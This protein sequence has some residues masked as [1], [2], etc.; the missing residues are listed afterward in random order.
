MLMLLCLFAGSHDRS[1]HSVFLFQS[2]LLF[3]I[4]ACTCL[5]NPVGKISRSLLFAAIWAP[6]VL[7]SLFYGMRFMANALHCVMYCGS[8]YL[9]MSVLCSFIKQRIAERISVVVPFV[10]ILF[11]VLLPITGNYILTIPDDFLTRARTAELLVWANPF[12]VVS[13]IWDVDL[14]RWG[15][16]YEQSVIGSSY[17]YRIPDFLA[18]SAAMLAASVLIRFVD[19]LIALFD[20]PAKAQNDSS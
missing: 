12:A 1:A 19:Y 13:G 7:I 17:P 11:V 15:W 9:L 16:V 14:M 2:I 3:F 4:T 10:V 20:E 6:F 5:V 18:P 8:F